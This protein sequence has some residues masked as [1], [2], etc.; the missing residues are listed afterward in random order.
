MTNVKRSKNELPATSPQATSREGALL[1]LLPPEERSAVVEAGEIQVYEN[2]EYIVVQG[3]AS[4]G[5]HVILQGIVESIY[6]DIPDRELT[7]AYWLNGDFVGAPNVLSHRPHIWSSKAIGR[8]QALWLSGDV[9]R[10][11][12]FRSPVF[13]V[14]LIQCLSFKAECYAKLAQT[15][16]TQSI[17]RRLA[18]VLLKRGGE[19]GNAEAD[20]I[21]LGK[22]RQRDLAKL[23]GATRQSVSLALRRLQAQNIIEIK[24]TIIVLIQ[25]DTLRRLSEQ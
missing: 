6:E 10:E 25:I 16:A 11:L 21:I 24:P 8:V 15:L 3:N 18:Q 12:V 5:L 22:M 4:D 14:T 17:E 1:E 9:L 13:A 19:Y 2:G 23:V 7:L 20:K